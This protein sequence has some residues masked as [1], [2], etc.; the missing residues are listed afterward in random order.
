MKKVLTLVGVAIVAS[1]SFNTTAVAQVEQGNVI[2]DPY[3]GVPTRNLIWG[4]LQSGS[5][6]N[7]GFSTVGP[8]ISFGG[9]AEFMAADNFGVG[10]DVNY[11]MSGFQYNVNDYYDDITEETYSANYK[12]QANILRAMLRL[13]YHFVQTDQLDAYFGVGA[14]YRNVTRTGSYEFDGQERDAASTSVTLIPLALRIAMG[15]R[16]YFTDN[17]GAHLELGL[18]GGGPI[19]F[20]VSIKI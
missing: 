20:G 15:G 8:P 9:R 10:V 17:I 4:N 2:I 3:I 1:M 7:D 13:N 16:Y 18:L 6:D 11:V 5:I 14:G 19:Q 12:Y